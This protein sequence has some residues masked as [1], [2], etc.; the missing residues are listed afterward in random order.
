MIEFGIGVVVGA[1][2]MDLM[3]A[4]KLG[5]PQRMWHRFR[6]RNDPKPVYDDWAED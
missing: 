1:V 6:H 3:W 4:W 2:V 5:I